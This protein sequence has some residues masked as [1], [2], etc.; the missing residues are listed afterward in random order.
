MTEG[1]NPALILIFG[2]LLVPLLRGRLRAAYLL[3]L[4]VLGLAQL[5]SLPTGEQGA[6]QVFD[7]ALVTL[8]LDP[9]SFVFALIFFVA[10]GLATLFALQVRDTLQHVA[11]LVYAGAA[12]GAVLAGDLV[13][14]FV[15][16]ELTAVASVLLIWARRSERALAAGMRY[17]VAQIG[18]G[19]LLLG[20]VVLHYHATGSLAF[21]PIG[22]ESPGGTWIFLAFG[23]KC[24]FPL[25]HNWL[26]DAYP[27][28]TGTGSVVLSIFTTKLAVYT[29]ARAFAGTELLVPIGAT[30]V[31]FP[32]FFALIESDL[33]R[34]LAYSLVSQLGFMVVAIGVGSELALNGALAHAVCH[35]LYKSLLFMSMGAVLARVGSVRIADLG[36][37]HRSMPWTTACCIVGAA[38]IAAVPLFCGFVSKTL[39][40]SAVAEQ[41]RWLTWLVLLFAS[42]AVLHYVAVR[43]PWLAF[44][45]EDSGKRC[46]EAP[47]TMLWAMGLT[48]ALCILI[49]VWPGLLYGLLPFP[50]DGSAYT[51]SHVLA[52]LQ[53]LL[54]SALALAL[55]MR[56]GLYPAAAAGLSLDSDWL[57]RR[58][59]VRVLLDLRRR[60]RSLAGR[61]AGDA[62]ARGGRVLAALYRHHGP[63]GALAKTWP[64]G[65]MVLWVSVLLAGFLVFYYLQS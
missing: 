3:L 19:V 34:V 55:L 32:I 64:T 56:S 42:A 13:T 14:L 17:L 47:A 58:G 59:L 63:R 24:A 27:E 45:G 52:Q 8:R 39:I 48:S 53:L 26:V 33:R 41:H 15:C 2:A 50:I 22:L 46:Q 30:M 20:G 57:Y 9:L 61:A 12:I 10:A 60:Y 43:V 5:V 40:L 36:G 7:L 35:I 23:I 16:W 11:A 38:S 25:L 18:S 62:D 44:F 51:P 54:F 6:L 29:L 1:L 28:A 37:L 31:A 21:G 4:P 49:G 65:S